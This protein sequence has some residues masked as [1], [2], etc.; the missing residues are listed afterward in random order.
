MTRLS[1]R[2]LTQDA[3]RVL[4][5]D[6]GAELLDTTRRLLSS[7]GLDVRTADTH[8]GLVRA[9][10][11]EPQVV[12]FD[13]DLGQGVGAD[14]VREIRQFDTLAQV[15]LVT[16]Y[17]SEQPARKLLEELD[18]QGYHDEADGAERLLVWIDASVQQY[19]AKNRGRNR[20]V[21]GGDE[22]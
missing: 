20:V 5:V 22:P 6:D 15:V 2:A 17:A 16:G 19:R 13:Y 1:K 10:A 12:L 4:V 9:R 8:S 7:H 21:V 11:F 14:F 3:P 18:I